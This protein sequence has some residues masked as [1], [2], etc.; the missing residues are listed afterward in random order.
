MKCRACGA[1]CTVISISSPIPGMPNG[2]PEMVPCI[3]LTTEMKC[4]LFGKSER[5]EVCSSYPA[6]RDVCGSS[7]EE[8]LILI[9]TLEKETSP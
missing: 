6:M 9:R 5:P 8:A 7:F 3:H 1:C 4:G 2:K